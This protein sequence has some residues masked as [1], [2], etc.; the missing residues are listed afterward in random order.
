MSN[1]TKTLYI[2]LF[3][4]SLF[5]FFSR[6]QQTFTFSGN[7][8]NPDSP[9]SVVAIVKINPGNIVLKPDLSGFFYTSLKEGNYT[10]EIKSFGYYP[11]KKRISILS[12]VN[13]DFQLKKQV[14]SL[15]EVVIKKKNTNDIKNPKL[16]QIEIS[17][18]DV[19]TLDR[20][21]VV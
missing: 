16:G 6:S 4:C 5:P 17:M 3:C 14:T 2:T 13:E 12:N 18:A 7:I 19:K 1:Y 8:N 11:I 15:K 9:D 10:I 20:K 21:S